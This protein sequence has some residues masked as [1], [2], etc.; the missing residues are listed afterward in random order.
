MNVFYFKSRPTLVFYSGIALEGHHLCVKLYYLYNF[1]YF[2][3][4][5]GKYCVMLIDEYRWVYV[6][7]DDFS[8]VIELT[9][10]YSSFYT[11]TRS[12]CI[13]NNSRRH[14]EY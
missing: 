14:G 2:V 3:F 8:I 6:R 11:F 4:T 12:K 7:S 9:H 10:L 5:V 1:D 13:V